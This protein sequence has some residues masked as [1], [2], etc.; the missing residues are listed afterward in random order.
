LESELESQMTM[1]NELEFAVR[2]MEGSLSE[3]QILVT[4]LREQLD[5]VKEI[6]L[7]LVG[8]L[9]K[10]QTELGATSQELN[11]LKTNFKVQSEE[12]LRIHDK[13]VFRII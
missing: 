4:N 9:Q 13:L 3:K 5:R 8:Q 7:D 11:E 6:N 10:L 1:K 2:L 12:K